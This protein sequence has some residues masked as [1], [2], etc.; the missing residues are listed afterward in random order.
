MSAFATLLF[1]I[2]NL[3]IG[4]TYKQDNGL[5]MLESGAKKETAD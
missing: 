5:Q 2:T 4:P 1:D 3:Y